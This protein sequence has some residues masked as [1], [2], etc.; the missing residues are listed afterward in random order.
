MKEMMLAI[1]LAGQ[2]AVANPP[3][4][5]GKLMVY[6]ENQRKLAECSRLDSS[7]K[8]PIVTGCV[9]EEGHTLDE[10]LTAILKSVRQEEYKRCVD[11]WQKTY[12]IAHSRKEPQVDE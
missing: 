6:D 10:V 1:L 11:N 2:A 8:N 9:I 5:T 7:W 3:L 4:T 12:D